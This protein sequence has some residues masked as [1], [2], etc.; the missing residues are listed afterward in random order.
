[1]RSSLSCDRW[2]LLRS[3]VVIALS[4]LVAGTASAKPGDVSA[5]G[6]APYQGKG[7]GVVLADSG[8]LIVVGS[9]ETTPADIL[10]TSFVPS[11][12]GGLTQDLSFGD[13]GKVVLD[14]GGDDVATAVVF[15]GFFRIYVA[16]YT[17]AGAGDYDF[18]VARF[19]DGGLLDTSY[20]NGTGWR[21]IG[22]GDNDFA[23][24][25]TLDHEGR[26][27]IAGYSFQ[28]GIF[29]FGNY[30][31][32]LTRIRPDGRVDTTF[33]DD[34][35]ILDGFGDFET[36]GSVLIDAQDRIIAVGAQRSDDS[37]DYANIAI[38]RYT[39]DG[40]RDSTFGAS[41]GN[42]RRTF[43][44]HYSYG[45]AATL[46][47]QGRLVVVGIAS[48]GHVNFTDDT[49]HNANIAVARF[50]IG[51]DHTDVTLDPTFGTNGVTFTDIAGFDDFVRAVAL[52]KHG[53]ILVAGEAFT[54]VTRPDFVVARYDVA[55]HLDPLFGSN[56]IAT[57]G[58]DV[59]GQPAARSLGFGLTFDPIGSIVVGGFAQE[60]ATGAFFQAVARFEVQQRDFALSISGPVSVPVGQSASTTVTLQ[61]IEDYDVS[62]P[63][64]V[65]GNATGGPLPNG[66]TVLFNGVAGNRI[67]MRPPPNGSI[68][69]TL[70]IR[71]ATSV[72]PRSLTLFLRPDRLQDPLHTHMVPVPVTI[73]A[74]PAS[75]VTVVDSFRAADAITSNVTATSL[76]ALV[77]TAQHAADAGNVD[78]ATIALN[79]FLLLVEL[80]RGRHIKT[81]AIVDGE[82]INPH[83]ILLAD[84]R[85]VLADLRAATAQHPIVGY[86][87]NGANQGVP[88]VTISIV[89]SANT[90]VAQAVTD[91]TGFYSI[92][93]SALTPGATYTAVVTGKPF[94]YHT[95]TPASQT[96]TWA[97][98]GVVLANFE[99]R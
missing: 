35:K 58:F 12:D 78:G 8:R 99:L 22:F 62:V 85:A 91:V 4:C 60:A 95:V 38:A 10:I 98:T 2:L 57:T 55:G 70:T 32:A 84:G 52:D 34:G 51:G 47:A 31:F 89:D 36:P 48:P 42:V 24:A 6:V 41:D 97:S 15:D 7:Y 28:G 96:L 92:T 13:H 65:A 74:R 46:D 25:M 64:V 71:V 44:T 93:T 3:V 16:G 79:G 39:P 30:D 43:G 63:V 14:L 29:E 90:V 40:G 88:T 83:A 56:G 86:V 73:T 27:V 18:F 9:T 20:N 77:T 19:F 80:E 11:F 53:K 75:I 17:S 94:F 76:N 45:T 59:G 50:D 37:G 66:V 68:S 72:T 1:M 23:T 26:I 5:R 33:G 81:S 82:T 49:Y 54:T 21:A 61:S 67:E 87:T 69:A